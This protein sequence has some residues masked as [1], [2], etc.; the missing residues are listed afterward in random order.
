MRITEL[1]GGRLELK[2]ATLYT[3]F[4]RL[5]N[6]GYIIAYWGDETTGARRRYYSITVTGRDKLAES[7]S[8]WRETQDTLN[9]LLSQTRKAPVLRDSRGGEI[10]VIQVEE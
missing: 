5:E 1:S 3:A 7:L 6:S 4:R 8:Q 9:A 10:P 2:E